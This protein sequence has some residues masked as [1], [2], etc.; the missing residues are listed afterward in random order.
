MRTAPGTPV[1]RVPPGRSCSAMPRESSQHMTRGGA[2]RLNR[3][4]ALAATM[5]FSRVFPLVA[6]A[7]LLDAC[8]DEGT[9]PTNAAPTAAFT[10]QCGPADCTFINSSTDADGTIEGYNWG[11]GDDSPHVTT[12]DA[13]H[14]YPA[15]GGRFTVTLTV[16]DDDGETATATRQVDVSEANVAPTADFSVSCTDLTCT[17][18]DGSFDG[19]VGGSVASYTWDFG[20]GGTSTQANPVHTYPAPGGHYTVAL[21]VTDDLGKTGTVSHVVIATVTAPPPDAPTAFPPVPVGALTY[22]RVAQPGDPTGQLSRYVLHQDGTFSLQYVTAPWGFFEYTGRYSRVNASIRLD[23]DASS[24]AGEWLATATVQG[25]SLV[26][27]YNLVMVLSDFV[28]GVYRLVPMP[29]GV[30]TS[31]TPMPELR[32]GAGAAALDG[33]VYVAGGI[34]SRGARRDIFAYDPRTDQW[35]T[36]GRLR[37]P[38]TGPGVAALGGRLYVVGG[39]DGQGLVSGDLQILDPATGRLEVGP[40]MPTHR[41]SLAVTVLHGRLHAIGGS[42]DTM[43]VQA[44]EVFDPSAGAWSS[45]ARPSIGGGGV[46]AA[47]VGG[48]IYLVGQGDRQLQVYDPLTDSWTTHDAPLDQANSAAVAVA[49][50]FYVLG[51]VDPQGHQ[52][53]LVYR[54]EPETGT[55]GQ[56]TPLPSPRSSPAVAVVGKSIYVISGWPGN[57]HNERYTLE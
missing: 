57:A 48:K 43:G 32:T 9:D 45:R 22:V 29:N 13:V 44:H 28:D 30:W 41:G 38:A 24:Q 54:F 53:D 23:F 7:A 39:W 14:T 55:W 37:Q 27:T 20:D 34:G 21:T 11:F 19:N 31:L 12:R 6:V 33:V 8:G 40:P 56:V 3:L 47:T 10:V 46:A 16:T 51:G 18:S 4:V 50:G 15:A 26:V 35:L 49:G 25:D 36:V 17:F 5:R 1:P 42:N 52:S 2:V